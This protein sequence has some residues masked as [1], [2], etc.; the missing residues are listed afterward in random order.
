MKICELLKKCFSFLFFFRINNVVIRRVDRCPAK[1]PEY[2]TCA[3]IT[4]GIPIVL[5]NNAVSMW[6]GYQL[7][8][9]HLKIMWDR[10]HKKYIDN[11]FVP[12]VIPNVFKWV[13]WE[14]IVFCGITVAIM[15]LLLVLK[16]IYVKYTRRSKEDDT[17]EIIS[18][19]NDDYG[20]SLTPHP[21]QEYPPIFEMTYQDISLD[22]PSFMRSKDERDDL[23]SQDEKETLSKID[24]VEESLGESGA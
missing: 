8:E 19:S 1:W 3:K 20:V 2:E 14:I 21:L 24:L 6:K 23:L 18:S 17:E 12:F 4:F 5:E 16:H 9:F 13:K 11:D 10:Y 15:L 22:P 7:N